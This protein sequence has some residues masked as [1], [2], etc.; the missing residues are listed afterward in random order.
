MSA[1]CR[2]LVLLGCKIEPQRRVSRCNFWFLILLSASGIFVSERY[3]LLYFCLHIQQAQD[4]SLEKKISTT[5]KP[6]FLLAR[7]VRGRPLHLLPSCCVCRGHA[8]VRVLAAKAFL[9]SR[10]LDHFLRKLLIGTYG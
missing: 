10:V 4:S 1:L 7:P 5:S 8:V 3:A 2:T 9:P 6:R